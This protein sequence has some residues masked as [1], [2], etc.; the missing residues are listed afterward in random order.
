MRRINVYVT[1]EIYRFLKES[2]SK[3]SDI[4]RYALEDYVEKSISMRVSA[5]KSKVK[6][7]E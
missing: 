4:V 3:L 5:S 1:D 2:E 7:R 6:E